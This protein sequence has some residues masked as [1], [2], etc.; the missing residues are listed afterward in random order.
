MK[1][2]TISDCVRVLKEASAIEPPPEALQR[3]LDR[4]RKAIIDGPVPA[5]HERP[6]TARRGG[7]RLL[8]IAA[9]IAAILVV[10]VAGAFLMLVAPSGA[11]SAFAQVQ[12]AFERVSF[13]SFSVEVLEAPEDVVAK[14]GTSF[15]DLERNRFRFESADGDEVHV[16]DGERGVFMS[17]YPKQQRAV[18]I[19]SPSA[20]PMPSFMN[21]LE[22]LR[23]CDP[24]LAERV[25]DTVLDGR[26][27]ERYRVLHEAPISGGV[28]T[29]V[30]VDP[31]T[32]L[33][34][35]IES[36]ADLLGH[37][38]SSNFSYDQLDPNLFAAVPPPGY[39]VDLGT[40]STRQ[41]VA[42]TTHDL[43]SSKV[44]IE[45]WGLRRGQGQ[46]QFGFQAQATASPDEQTPALQ[47][48]L[49]DTTP[50][51][52][53]VQRGKLDSGL[54]IYLHKEPLLT[55][56]DIDSVTLSRFPNHVTEIQLDF[57][58]NAADRLAAATQKNIGKRLAV[59]L[60]GEIIAAPTI[61]AKL[62]TKASLSGDF[63]DETVSLLLEALG[64]NKPHPRNSEPVAPAR[65][66]E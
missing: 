40:V 10:A 13:V 9:A 41:P 47:F 25:E 56:D 21:F 63:S 66:A 14:S 54:E 46:D 62:S 8:R 38:V 49:A 22:G 65:E 34:V 35:R 37:A 2:K 39:Q 57:E 29:L 19:Q 55:A 7:R 42:V 53:F 33:P 18:V 17:L 16:T 51:D 48:R 52:T 50:S 31:E 1:D 11:T 6:A 3:A 36:K 20:A 23:D 45:S 43:R 32:H 60:D 12:S 64:V 30:S 4:T 61:W 15:I 26:R 44:D 59:I 58:K 27:L 5:T 28:D 24:A